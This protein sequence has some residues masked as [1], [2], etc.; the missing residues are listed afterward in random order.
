M[1]TNHLLE[2]K[3]SRIA[4]G[5]FFLFIIGMA[6]GVSCTHTGS[7]TSDREQLTQSFRNPPDTARPGVYWYFMDGNLSREGMTKDLESMKE[8]GI[9]RV[10][11]LEVNV[12]VPRG[13]VDF[14]SEEWQDLFQHAVNESERLGIE[15]IMGV[16]PGWTGSGGPWVPAKQSMRHLVASS[17][18]VKGPGKCDIKLSKPAPRRP[19]FGE[20]TLTPNLKKQWNDYYEDVVALAFPTPNIK[21][22][23]SDIDEKALYYRAPYSSQEGVKPYLPAPADWPEAPEEADVAKEKV[24]NVTQYM[25]PD[26]SFNW[27]V[28]EGEWTIMRFGMRNNGAVTRPAPRPGLGFECDKFSQSAFDHHFDAYLKKLI[29]QADP[30]EKNNHK[31]WTRLHMDSWEMGAQNWT[32][33]FREKFRE[34]RGYDPL[35]FLPVYNGHIIGS[36]ELSE[37]FLWDMRMVSQELVLENHVGR[38]RELGDQYGF[39]LSI[40]PYDMNPTADLA[41]GALADVPMCEF[42]SRG[43]G[44]NTTYSVIEATSIAHVKGK[45]VVA[46]EAFTAGH[47]EAWKQYPG[48]MK[49]QGDWAFCAGINRFLYHTFAHKPLSEDLRPGMT[50]G[51][52]GVH[53]DRKQTWWPMA[54]GYHR[55]ISR[56]QHMLQQGR[57]VSDIL[58]L[59][60][61]GAPHIFRPPSDALTGNDTLPDRRGYNFDGVSPVTF[62]SDAS[63]KDQRIVFPGGASYKILL[64]PLVQTMTPELLRKI[65]SL[66]DKGALVVGNPPIQSPSLVNYPQCDSVV[67]ELAGT[68]WGSHETPSEITGKEYGQGKIFWGGDLTKSPGDELYPSYQST[69]DLMEMREVPGDFTTNGPIRYTHRKNEEM[70][71]YFVSNRTDRSLET[72]CTFRV[73]NG[74]PELWNPLN[75]NIRKLP[76]YDH[77]D[78]RTSVPLQFEPHQSYFLV[79]PKSEQEEGSPDTEKNFPEKHRIMTLAGPWNVSFDPEWGGPANAVFDSL[80]DWTKRSEEG[81]RHYSGIASYTKTFKLDDLAK[82]KSPHKKYFID[83]GKVNCMARIIVNGKDQGVVWTDPWRLEITEALHEGENKLEIRVANLWVNRLIGDASRPDQG[84][85]GGQWPDWLLEDESRPGDR[86][87][88]TTYNYYNPNSRLMPSGLLGP[89]ILESQ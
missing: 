87:T 74:A 57:A 50:M 49:N 26:G 69:A 8:A 79:F 27:D 4:T 81:I 60:P 53:W 56:C 77:N 30:V 25:E 34:S 7:G 6:I 47:S 54:E 35:P 33:G 65:E 21:E 14:L 89:V 16:G 18:K 20:G 83:L 52:Y 22:R 63:V 73:K 67:N 85:Q 59:T 39:D 11:F 82:G 80:T 86:Y 62:I 76:Q 68:I 17:E 23:I 29:S 32:D 66:V 71:I 10:I 46:A 78:G 44:F 24:V 75:G 72:E 1:E 38:I 12:G 88:F 42:W 15:L 55:Y 2:K 45:P 48:S 64:L 40:E 5:L 70:D 43:Y 51:P 41:L 84:I 36:R 58:Y 31:G 61:E 3:T 9:G 28:P 19:F 37:R 13:E